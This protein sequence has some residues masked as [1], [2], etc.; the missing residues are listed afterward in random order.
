[1]QQTFTAINH[2]KSRTESEKSDKVTRI[3]ERI[4]NSDKPKRLPKPE[5]KT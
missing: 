3:M 5:K 4:I 1:M 2:Y